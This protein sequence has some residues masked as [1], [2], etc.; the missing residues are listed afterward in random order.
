MLAR[1]ALSI[2]LLLNLSL[3]ASDLERAAAMARWPHSDAERVRFHDRYLFLTVDPDAS[4]TIEAKVLQI[5][6]V[7]EFRRMELIAEEH[8]RLN[9][10]FGRGGVDELLTAIRPWKGKLAI[11]VHVQLPGC[12]EGCTP[13][14]PATDVV[15]DGVGRALATPAV[16]APFYARTGLSPTA[17]GSMAEALFD[18]DAVGQ[19]TH[20][21]RVFVSGRELARA[22]I[23]FA[24]LE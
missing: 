11:Y 4:R 20:D 21:V 24:S 16:R 22:G 2:A 5:E 7:T 13:P 3:S 17:L 1:A 23:D 9:D 12:G 19:S 10:S 18:A 14:I 6:I 8:V 15:I